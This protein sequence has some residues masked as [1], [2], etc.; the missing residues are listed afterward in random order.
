MNMS[1]GRLVNGSRR[2]IVPRRHE[3]PDA[4]VA[5]SPEP[6]A[7]LDPDPGFSMQA[8]VH[9]QGIEVR[10]A[11]ELDVYTAFMFTMALK[12]LERLEPATII[13]DMTDLEFIDSSGLTALREARQRADQ[14]G[15]ILTTKRPGARVR[16]FLTLAGEGA[17]LDPPLPHLTNEKSDPQ[18]E[19]EGASQ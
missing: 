6:P 3:F 2:A 12:R 11:G 4:G 7:H 15:R 17:L 19:Q 9:K 8:L 1:I 16:R 18:L 13:V 5:D 10:I 14:A